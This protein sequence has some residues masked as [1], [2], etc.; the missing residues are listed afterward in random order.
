MLGVAFLLST[1]FL[2]RDATR[3][4]LTDAHWVIL[5]PLVEQA[6]RHA[7]GK[8][9]QL[10]DRMFFEAILFWART[11]IPWRDLPGEFG[12]WD[13]VYNRLGRWVRSGSL[14]QL[15]ILLTDSPNLGEVR[16]VLIDGTTLRAHQ[17]AAGA[18]RKKKKLGR[19]AA[20]V[21]KPLAAAG[22]GARP[23]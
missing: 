5:G 3:Y 19:P 22:A 7:C 17:H 15:F 16:R 21:R 4:M 11:G 20:R 9:P 12:S 23:R 2:G 13:A 8:P 18:S 10:T 6:K 14:E 1:V